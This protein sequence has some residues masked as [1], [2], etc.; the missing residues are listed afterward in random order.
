MNVAGYVEAIHEIA[1]NLNLILEF[2]KHEFN[3]FNK[4]K[5]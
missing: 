3:E 4:R 1:D 5:M 2:L